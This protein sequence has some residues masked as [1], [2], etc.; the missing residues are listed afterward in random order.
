MFDTWAMDPYTSGDPE[1]QANSPDDV[2]F[3]DLPRVAALLRAAYRAHHIISPRPP[4]FW[5][6]E[7]S[8]DSKPPDPYGVPLTLETRW[9]A[10]A[11]Y[12]AWVDGISLLSWFQI[13]DDPNPAGFQSGLYYG[14]A[15]GPSCDRPKPILAA[16]RFPFVAY[17]QRHNVLVW[18]RTPWGRPGAVVVEQR[19]GA[20][21]RR[22]A[23][24]RT[25]RYGVF[26]ATLST[27]ASGDLRARLP[28]TGGAP[29]E[30]APF[31][32]HVPPDM[33]VN[34]FGH[35]PPNEPSKSK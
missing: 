18:G 3:G 1:H 33:L 35:T 32:L 10:E 8:W 16:F 7:F 29:V 24:V 22:L 23:T 21:W 9:V 27:S 17:R 28:G 12:R 34:P 4:Q 30:S 5:I 15:N 31:S 2:S 25:D 13:R 19:K 14:C 26:T 20:G 6:T 11:I